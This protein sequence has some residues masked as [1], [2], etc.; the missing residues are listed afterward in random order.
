[1]NTKIGLVPSAGHNIPFHCALAARLYV[2]PVDELVPLASNIAFK[3]NL[4]FPV[5]INV[6]VVAEPGYASTVAD[7]GRATVPLEI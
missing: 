7:K 2:P 1:M 5:T 4:S 6:A 3:Y